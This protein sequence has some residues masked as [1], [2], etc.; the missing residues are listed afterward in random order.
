MPYRGKDCLAYRLGEDEL[1][2]E[3]LAWKPDVLLR[4][5]ASVLQWIYLVQSP[6]VDCSRVITEVLHV[7]IQEYPLKEPVV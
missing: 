6:E 7:H 5:D 2:L 4:K 3:T 1:T